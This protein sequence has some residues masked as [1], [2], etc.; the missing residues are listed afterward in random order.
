MGAERR[1]GAPGWM[2]R[3]LDGGEN[4]N[5][6]E[7]PTGRAAGHSSFDGLNIPTDVDLRRTRKL[8]IM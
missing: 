8:F 3:R 2:K 1:L 6:M 5:F 7:S 4:L